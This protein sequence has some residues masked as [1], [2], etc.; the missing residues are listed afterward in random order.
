M[1]VHHSALFDGA[2]QPVVSVA[3][4]FDLDGPLMDPARAACTQSGLL[5]HICIFYF[6]VVIQ[7]H[8]R[9]VTCH[10]SNRWIVFDNQIDPKQT[11]IYPKPHRL[12]TPCGNPQAVR[13]STPA[14]QIYPESWFKRLNQLSELCGFGFIHDRKFCF[15]PRSWALPAVCSSMTSGRPTGTV[16]PRVRRYC[17]SSS[18][19]TL[20]C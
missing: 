2:S 13:I 17:R 16:G 3:D 4:T 15:G 18:G 11:F 9:M 8:E 20:G 14:T 5:P 1:H 7:S 19:P 12:L 10:R 6:E